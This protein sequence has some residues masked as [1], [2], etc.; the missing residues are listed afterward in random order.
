MSAPSPAPQPPQREP[1]QP[2]PAQAQASR[3]RRRPLLHLSNRVKIWFASL[4]S[5]ASG[6]VISNVRELAV[7]PPLV[8]GQDAVS[9]PASALARV[10]L[11]HDPQPFINI[12]PASAEVKTLLVFYPGGRVRPQ[13]YEWLGRALA[14]RGVQTV[15]PAFLLD[16]AITGTERAEGLIARYGAGKRVVLAGHSLGGTVAAQYAALRPDKID[17]L[18]LL[19]AYPAPNVNLHDARFPALSLLAE[20]DGVADAGLVRGGLERLPKNTRLTVLPGAV[21]S[22]FG[23]YGPQQGDGVPTVSRARAE[24]EIVQAVETFIDQLPPHASQ[25]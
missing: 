7:R 13:A 5:L 18:L 10:T 2:P 16:L 9:T 3:P 22:F 11:E 12:V 14:V 25:P 17:G 19:A 21:H 4:L 20:K 23:R 24:R 1:P 8:L 6:Y 15:I